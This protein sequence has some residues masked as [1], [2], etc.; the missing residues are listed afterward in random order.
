VNPEYRHKKLF[1]DFYNQ[2]PNLKGATNEGVRKEKR[3]FGR[4]YKKMKER[5]ASTQP[6]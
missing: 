1:A 3:A 6:Y 2:V 4:G 5:R